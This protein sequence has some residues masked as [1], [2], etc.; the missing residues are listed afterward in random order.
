MLRKFL[1]SVFVII[2]RPVERLNIPQNFGQD[3]PPRT[4]PI[5]GLLCLALLIT[6]GSAGAFAQSEP[7]L[8]IGFKPYGSYHGN[9][10]DTLGL[11]NGNLSLHIPYPYHYPQ[12][13]GRLD[14]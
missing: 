10:V 8:E 3:Q 12:R 14:D 6:V 5:A 7:N 4:S 1:G 11:M 2:A 13:G 9:E